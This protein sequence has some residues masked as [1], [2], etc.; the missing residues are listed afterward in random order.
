MPAELMSSVC[1]SASARATASAPTFPPAPGRHSPTAP[2]STSAS[3]PGAKGA[4]IFTAFDGYAPCAA[5]KV[6]DTAAMIA[7]PIIMMVFIRAMVIAWGQPPLFSS[8]PITIYAFLGRNHENT[9][10]L[11]LRALLRHH[12]HRQPGPPRHLVC[13]R[14]PRPAHALV[15][16]RR[17]TV[18]PAERPDRDVR[19]QGG[20]RK[21]P[22]LRQRSAPTDHAH[23]R[24]RR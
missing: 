24:Q 12:R 13:S 19:I 3:P 8:F 6:A 11:H 20:G 10:R 18:H 4:T 22:G 1:P 17:R 14:R 2:A 15:G 23:Q 5:A 9:C 21:A 7:A 16:P